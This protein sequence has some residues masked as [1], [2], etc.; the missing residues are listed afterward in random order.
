MM[1]SPEL[2]CSQSAQSVEHAAHKHA[3]P[4]VVRSKSGSRQ[5]GL[6]FNAS[7]SIITVEYLYN[8]FY[9]LGQNE[10]FFKSLPTVSF[11]TS[12][13]FVQCN[14]VFWVLL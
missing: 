14:T 13:A 7:E 2:Q 1:V 9:D 4:G 5:F 12:A 11:T 3:G 6:I 8:I 10:L